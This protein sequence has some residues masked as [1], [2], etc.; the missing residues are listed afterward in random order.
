MLHTS[1]DDV[2]KHQNVESTAFFNVQYHEAQE[3]AESLQIHNF[4]NEVSNLTDLA[5]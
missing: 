3:D 2:V 1:L 5:I 4:D